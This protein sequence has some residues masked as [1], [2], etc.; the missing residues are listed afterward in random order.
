MA[1]LLIIL[2][3]AA[4]VSLGFWAFDHQD[5]VEKLL[6]EYGL[7]E[8]DQPGGLARHPRARTD[9]LESTANE[10][11]SFKVLQELP[12]RLVLE[13]AYEYSGAC[14]IP[15]FLGAI[16]MK[17]GVSTGNWS[18]SHTVIQPGRHT[19]QITIGLNKNAPARHISDGLQFAMSSKQCRV[20]FQKAFAYEK[21]WVRQRPDL[22]APNKR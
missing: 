12:H 17:D 19:A 5:E 3:I 16:T 13:V 7:V 14:G 18:Y 20:F 9:R 1:R 8:D 21:N 10:V 11:V 2:L 15:A 22:S 4:L 6:R